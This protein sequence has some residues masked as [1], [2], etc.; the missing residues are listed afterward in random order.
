MA[1][2]S[3]RP[4]DRDRFVALVLW[5]HGLSAG[6]IALFLGRT[7]KSALS[8]CQKAPYPPR[9]SMTLAERQAALD[10]LR[11][12]RAAESGEF[13]DGGMLPDRVFTPR[14]LN[15]NQT[16]GSRTDQRLSVG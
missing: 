5:M 14:P 16:I 10:E 12:V 3:S 9:A 2:T 4:S 8:L 13:V 15:G 7:R 1:S 11:L 6:D